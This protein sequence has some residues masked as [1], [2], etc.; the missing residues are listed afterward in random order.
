MNNKY[1]S[2]NISA[3]YISRYCSAVYLEGLR[4]TTEIVN[5]GSQDRNLISA[6]YSSR[7]STLI[8][9]P[10]EELYYLYKEG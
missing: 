9:C 4:K 10:L 6:E 8:Y 2:V 3:E 1:G 5:E 7:V